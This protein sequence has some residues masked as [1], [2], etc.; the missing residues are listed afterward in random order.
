M[1]NMGREEDGGGL[2]ILPPPSLD[3]QVNTLPNTCTHINS[4]HVVLSVKSLVAW[5]PEWDRL[6]WFGLERGEI[7]R[8]NDIK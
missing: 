1:V 4:I 6:G 8:G 2:S 7:K 3:K 5:L